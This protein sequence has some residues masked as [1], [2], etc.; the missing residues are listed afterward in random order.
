[1]GTFIASYAIVSL[2]LVLYLAWLRANQRRLDQLAQTLESRIQE[3]RITAETSSQADL[4][5]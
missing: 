4:G 2:A 3:I 5:V 1:M